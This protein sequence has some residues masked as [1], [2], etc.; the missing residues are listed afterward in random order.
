MSDEVSYYKIGPHKIE[1]YWISYMAFSIAMPILTIAVLLLGIQIRANA[2]E[3]YDINFRTRVLKGQEKPA[4]IITANSN[5]KNVV[6]KLTRDD[7]QVKTLKSALIRYGKQ[8]ELTFDQE[9]GKHEYKIELTWAERKEPEM[10]KIDVVVANPMQIA[11]TQDT[12]DLEKGSITFTGSEAVAKVNLELFGES[13]VDLLTKEYKTASEPGQPTTI[14][15]KPP[16][17]AITRVV[18]T[19][20]DPYGFYNGI[21]MSPFFVQVP[22]SKEVNF[23]SGKWDIL[24]AEEPKLS[25]VLEKVFAALAQLG[26]G[27][28]ANLYV[29]GYTDTVGSRE[30]NQALSEKRARAI[31]QWFSSNGLKI[32]AC[33]QGF[34]EDVLAVPT[35]DETDEVRNRRTIFV[36]ASSP[37]PKSTTFPR[38]SWKCL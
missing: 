37:P 16:T 26:G 9:P 1:R 31:S 28:K 34:G 7:N 5:L 17:S 15:F 6:V 12:V 33:Y 11:I 38:Q 21:Q 18:L 3:S 25:P 13:G 23:E 10:F 19:A 32:G 29:A 2:Q 20:T 30:S 24:P 27:F 4:I 36:I 22:N 14:Q 8:Q 35:P